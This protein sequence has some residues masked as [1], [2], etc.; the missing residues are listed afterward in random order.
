[1]RE[2]L[3]HKDVCNAPG[4]TETRSCASEVKML[5]ELKVL[6]PFLFH[7]IIVI[8]S[9]IIKFITFK[10]KENYFGI[11]PNI[12]LCWLCWQILTV[13]MNSFVTGCATSCHDVSV[14]IF[15]ISWVIRSV[16]EK[17]STREL[18]GLKKIRLTVCHK[19]AR[20]RRVLCF[21]FKMCTYYYIHDV[22]RVSHSWC[23]TNFKLY[24]PTVQ[25]FIWKY[26]AQTS[27][28]RAEQSKNLSRVL[29]FRALR[30]GSVS[31]SLRVVLYMYQHIF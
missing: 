4:R 1:M 10:N 19:F 8:L 17:I 11:G 25:F 18:L 16:I 6:I 13:C 12:A 30:A 29:H 24:E 3:Q 26:F 20:S 5:L 15:R 31:E 14:I 21:T 22:S 23:V 7:F 27:L 28:K 9:F 2:L